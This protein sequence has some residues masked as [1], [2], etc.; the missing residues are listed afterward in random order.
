[1]I[2]AWRRRRSTSS[3][4]R[5]SELDVPA[6]IPFSRLH[7]VLQ[8]AFAWRDGHLHE[9]VVGGERIGTSEGEEPSVIDERSRLLRHVAAPGAR[10]T[11]RYD[12]GDAWEHEVVVKRAFEADDAWEYP[13]IY[14]VAHRRPRQVPHSWEDRGGIGAVGSSRQPG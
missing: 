9:F 5:W 12:F 7:Q 6:G 8:D 11:C 4:S 13:R 3:R 10:F 14:R 1:M 2:G